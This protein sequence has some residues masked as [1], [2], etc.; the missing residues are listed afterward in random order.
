MEVIVG[1]LLQQWELIS[2]MAHSNGLA[3]HYHDSD[4]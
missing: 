1:T 4:L 3:P 2:S